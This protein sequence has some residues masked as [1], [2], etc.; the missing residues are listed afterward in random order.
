MTYFSVCS[1][2]EAA[3][4]AW[5]ALGWKPV[6]F[7][8]IE[9]FPC[10]VLKQRFPNVKNYGDMTKFKD[11]DVKKGDF[12]LLVGGTPCQAF[13]TAGFRKGLNDPRGNLTLVF[14]SMVDFY[15]PKY[16]VW[17]NV[18]GILS[19]KTNAFSQFLH[20][21]NEIGY[22]FDTDILDAQNFGVPQRRK[23]VFVVAI[24]AD[25]IN[26]N[27]NIEV[28]YEKLSYG[29]L[30]TE[31]EIRM[32][33]PNQLEKAKDK[34]NFIKCSNANFR[35]GIEKVCAIK[36]F[37]QRTFDESEKEKQDDSTELESGAR[38]NG[39]G[40]LKDFSLNNESSYGGFIE[41]STAGALT[42]S[43]GYCSGGG[44]NLLVYDIHIADIKP[45]DCKKGVVAPILATYSKQS[46]VPLIQQ[47]VLYKT[48]LMDTRIKECKDG[49]ADTV[50]AMGDVPFIK[51][52]DAECKSIVRRL[53]PLECE[54][55]QGFPDNWTRIKWRGKDE[56]ECPD[57]L[58]YK[59]CGNSM[60][61]PV[62]QY[63]GRCIDVLEN[64]LSEYKG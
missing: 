1:G 24:N 15:K 16:I 36:N 25:Y 55:L 50:N 30:Y 12:D 56:S 53:T 19:D 18:P 17:E 49:V 20:G 59:A 60:A 39:K 45:R 2:I 23:R 21:L 35:R 33:E 11:W 63:I 43:G 61:T 42:V 7:S 47:P 37:M 44:E 29:E 38:G 26:S 62:M 3:S 14:L 32:R 54:R 52:N 13:S 27:F 51:Q 6:G 46:S 10:E 8:E 57:S 48:H 64:A 4:V 41:T 34:I 9:A 22:I 31:R 40:Q 58:R 5:K 28:D